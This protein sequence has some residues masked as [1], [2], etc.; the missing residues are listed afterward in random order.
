M[1]PNDLKTH[2]LESRYLYKRKYVVSDIILLDTLQTMHRGTQL[3]FTTSDDDAGL[4][5]N[6]AV[7]RAPETCRSHRRPCEPPAL[8]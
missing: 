4:V 5:R 7:K 6:I 1:L 2:A 8:N 3:K